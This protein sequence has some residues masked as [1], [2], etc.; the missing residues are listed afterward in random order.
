V[1]EASTELDPEQ[2]LQVCFQVEQENQRTR[3]VSKGPRTLDLDIIFYEDQVIRT[4]NLSIPHPGL[5][6][7][8][9]VLAPLAEIA[10]E[11]VDPVSRKTVHQ[12]L[13]ECQDRALIQRL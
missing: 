5:A 6:S 9:F 10:P 1:V 12:L 13:T 11:F 7:R 3:D 8:L 2:L 4:A